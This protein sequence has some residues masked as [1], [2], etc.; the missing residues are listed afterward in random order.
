MLSSLSDGLHPRHD[1]SQ[2]ENTLLQSNLPGISSLLIKERVTI[3]D[4]RIFV[5]WMTIND[6]IIPLYF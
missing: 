5:V 6:A 2:D 4:M 1:Q 3:V